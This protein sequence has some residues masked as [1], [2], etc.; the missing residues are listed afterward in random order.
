M[1]IERKNLR[2]VSLR[3]IS[4]PRIDLRGGG[5]NPQDWAGY[6]LELD[7]PSARTLRNYTLFGN[8]SEDAKGV[9]D[10]VVQMMATNNYIER[11]SQ[12][13][14][15]T[16]GD[17]CAVLN[18]TTTARLS[19]S[20]TLNIP[21]VTGHRYLMYSTDNNIIIFRYFKS[22]STTAPINKNNVFVAPSDAVAIYANY[23]DLLQ[24]AGRVFNNYKVFICIID[25][26]ASSPI[27]ATL[28]TADEFAQ[29]LGYADAAHLPPFPYGSSFVAPIRVGSRNLWD[30]EMTW[31]YYD[32]DTGVIAGVGSNQYISSKNKI[33]VLPATEIGVTAPV[34]DWT[35]MLIYEYDA[36]GIYLGRTTCQIRGGKGKFTTSPKTMYM[37]FST[38]SASYGGSTYNHDI[39]INLSDEHNGEY[40]PYFA[41]TLYPSV[42]SSPL[43]K[44]GDIVD[45]KESNGKEH[46]ALGVV[47]L[48]SLNWGYSES[49]Q[50]F[51]CAN[52][53]FNTNTI[54]ILCSRYATYV[55]SFAGVVQPDMTIAGRS[56]TG[57]NLFIA[58]SRYTSVAEFKASLAGLMLVYPL[59]TPTE[60]QGE[61]LPRLAIPKG[62]SIVTLDTAVEPS[63]ITAKI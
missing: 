35:N 42:L 1:R 22:D 23:Y 29:R 40:S 2:G 61:P 49:G 12:G 53:P 46:H 6:P 14:E 52:L 20:A 10:E 34:L 24:T 38:T 39:C 54:N 5:D 8:T 30:E 58:D 4:L 37:N 60:V 43:H 36:F 26:D 57:T 18:G 15:I 33:C 50:K 28:T 25:L 16:R 59:A 17:N 31:G 7:L 21:C 45:Y 32:T 27:F 9:G 44:I 3:G 63:N 41:P 56:Q 55:P 47:D 51:T 19:A 62:E 48:G 13:V 11:I